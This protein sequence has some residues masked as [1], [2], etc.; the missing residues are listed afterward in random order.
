MLKWNLRSNIR[1]WMKLNISSLCLH[2]GSTSHTDWL[3]DWLIGKGTSYLATNWG[4]H[5]S[6]AQSPS[7][8]AV[9]SAAGRLVVPQPAFAACTAGT[10]PLYPI[11]CHKNPVQPFSGTW[12]CSS[13]PFLASLGLCCRQ[14][15]DHTIGWNLFCSSLPFCRPVEAWWWLQ[16]SWGLW[17]P[18]EQQKSKFKGPLLKTFYWLCCSVRICLSL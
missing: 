17:T 7:L 14:A 10:G 1:K 6:K 3:I 2:K 9:S 8:Q 18:R 4:Y 16:V 15:A 12:S 5:Q 11:T 13:L